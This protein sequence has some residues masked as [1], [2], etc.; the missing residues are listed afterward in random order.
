MPSSQSP[1]ILQFAFVLVFLTPS[2]GTQ[3]SNSQPPK[4]PSTQ[5]HVFTNDDV[6]GAAP[7]SAY[8]APQIPGLIQCG[9]DLKCFLK[10]LDTATPAA[11]TRIETVEVGTA[12]L[13]SNSTWWTTQFTGARSTVSFRVDSLE[14]KVNPKVVPETSAAYA[15]VEAKLAEMLRDFGGEI[16]GQTSTCTL[17]V[18]DLKA[19]MTLPSGSL[20]GLGPA[21]NFGKN[22][23]GAG[24]G[25]THN[26]APDNLK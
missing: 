17:S 14:A 9:T 20:L 4:A 21:S 18:Q 10:A 24:F 6:E 19:L 5:R 16:R 7:Q 15:A 26:S 25:P 23:T 12:I 13:A 2:L 22:C 8:L 11:V 3:Q 1:L